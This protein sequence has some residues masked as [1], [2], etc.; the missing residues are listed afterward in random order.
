MS[1]KEKIVDV[2]SSGVGSSELEVH[3]GGFPTS[4]GSGRGYLGSE[5]VSTSSHEIADVS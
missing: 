5:D 2:G 3:S 4:T 1:G